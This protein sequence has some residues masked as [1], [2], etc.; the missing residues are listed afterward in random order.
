MSEEAEATS[1]I[2]PE[3]AWENATE[4]RRLIGAGGRKA[5]EVEVEINL[6]KWREMKGCVED[7]LEG[8]HW[9]RVNTTQGWCGGSESAGGN[10]GSPKPSIPR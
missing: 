4:V 9:K 7:N 3:V 1:D 10:D 6:R 5:L 8:L 2:P